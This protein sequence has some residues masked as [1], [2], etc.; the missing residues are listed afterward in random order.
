MSECMRLINMGIEIARD[1]IVN[2]NRKNIDA[3]ILLRIKNHE[4][5]YE[6]ILGMCEKRKVEMDEIMK[7]STIPDKP[8]YDR[9]NKILLD[10]RKTFN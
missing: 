7:T 10:I 6:E 4:F 3:D 2:V 9:L 1:G 5:S 8:D